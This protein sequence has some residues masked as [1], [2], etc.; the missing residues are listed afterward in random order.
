LFLIKCERREIIE[1]GVGVG[2]RMDEMGRG[3]K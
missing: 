1:E 3:E 2:N